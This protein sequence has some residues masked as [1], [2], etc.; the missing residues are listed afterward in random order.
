M[1][2]HDKTNNINTNYMSYNVHKILIGMLISSSLIVLFND[3]IFAAELNKYLQWLACGSLC[4]IAICSFAAHNLSIAQ[5]KEVHY[6][7]CYI[8]HAIYIKFVSTQI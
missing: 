8:V 2:A 7:T 4:K 3:K 1:A 5:G 6:L